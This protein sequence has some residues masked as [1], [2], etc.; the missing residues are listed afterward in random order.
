[1][2]MRQ[3]TSNTLTPEPGRRVETGAATGDTLATYSETTGNRHAWQEFIDHRLVD[4]GRDP[5]QLGDSE[6]VPPTPTAIRRAISFALTLREGDLP[7]PKR[8]VPD[9]DGGI[10]IERWHGPVTVSIEISPDGLAE[11]VECREGRVVSRATIE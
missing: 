11:F 3:A 8:I 9:G 4:W 7:P 1:M 6:L 5:L 2:K 10:V